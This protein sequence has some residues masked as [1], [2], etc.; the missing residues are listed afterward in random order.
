[1]A[2][3]RSSRTSQQDTLVVMNDHTGSLAQ[4]R[5]VVQQF[6]A[7][8]EWQQFHTPKNLAM[9]LAI[10]AA[11]LMEHF[12]WLSAEQSRA[13]ADDPTELAEVADEMADVFCYLMAL[14]NELNVD[15]SAALTA[16]MV[17][18]RLKYPAPEFRG[19]YGP[20]DAGR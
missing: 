6:V 19:R 11:E 15:L 1:M 5:A 10:E 20:K 8:R 12:Q 16:K 18:N 17:K 4:L 9:S 7:E 2:A 3:K 14:A 13:L